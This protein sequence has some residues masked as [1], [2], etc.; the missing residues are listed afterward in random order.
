MLFRSWKA[1][2]VFVVPIVLL[3]EVS[4]KA[5]LNRTLVLALMTVLLIVLAMRLKVP[6]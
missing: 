5:G 6:A 4:V 1:V 2:A 3:S